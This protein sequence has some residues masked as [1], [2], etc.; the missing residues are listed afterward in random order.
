MRF[1]DRNGDPIDVIEYEACMMDPQQTRRVACTVIPESHTFVSTVWLGIDH[2]VG[3]GKPIIFETLVFDAPDGDDRMRR[4]STE[5]EA[6]QGHLDTVVALLGE[7]AR[8]LDL[9]QIPMDDDT[10]R[11]RRWVVSDG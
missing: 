7:S 8:H 10:P 9:T 6:L 5:A 1:Y 2:G 11:R 4:Y 3:F